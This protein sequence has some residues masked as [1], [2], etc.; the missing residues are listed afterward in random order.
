MEENEKGG[1]CCGNKKEKKKNK[2]KINKKIE[3]VEGNDKYNEEE[4]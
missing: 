1:G 3:I 4:F 2:N